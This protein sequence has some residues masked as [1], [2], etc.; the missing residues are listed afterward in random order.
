MKM[1]DPRV[2]SCCVYICVSLILHRFLHPGFSNFGHHHCLSRIHSLYLLPLTLKTEHTIPCIGRSG[3]S[4]AQILEVVPNDQVCDMVIVCSLMREHCGEMTAY[5][6]AQ[7]VNAPDNAQLQDDS[8]DTINALCKA[9]DKEDT[10][11]LRRSPGRPGLRCA[12]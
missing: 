8:V 11:L 6:I 7:A 12:L 5:Q 4:L 9:S 2:W 1:V 3:R 10:V